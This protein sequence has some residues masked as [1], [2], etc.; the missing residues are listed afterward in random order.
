MTLKVWV[1]HDRSLLILWWSKDIL[2][3]LAVLSVFCRSCFYVVS[4]WNLFRK[5]HVL[6]VSINQLSK[7][8]VNESSLQTCIR[9]IPPPMADSVSL[10]T[11]LHT[12]PANL[13][14]QQSN[15]SLSQWPTL[16]RNNSKA[17]IHIL[18]S[19]LIRSLMKCS[20]LLLYSNPSFYDAD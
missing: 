2:L 20:L 8:F 7:F 3:H 17:S 16:K 19:S 6:K 4:C 11:L 13:Q 15:H 14:W 12:Y 18:E 10:P 9:S 5:V 1:S